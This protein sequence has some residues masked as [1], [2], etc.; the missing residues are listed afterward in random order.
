MCIAAVWTNFTKTARE[1]ASARP[2]RRL[3]SNQSKTSELII[4]RY[5]GA[6]VG[7]AK[8]NVEGQQQ[9]DQT[10][11]HNCLQI[12]IC[13]RNKNPQRRFFS[14]MDIFAFSLCQWL[15]LSDL[16]FRVHSRASFPS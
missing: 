8:Q 2:A 12:G 7:K 4:L 14:R 1:A 6:E 10:K 15:K 16:R 9:S 3:C 5:N 13:D 11:C